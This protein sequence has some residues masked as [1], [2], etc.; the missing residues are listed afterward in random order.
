[1][2]TTYVKIASVSVGSG[3]ASTMDFTSIPSTYT[4]LV[5]KVSSR[6]TGAGSP[7]LNLRFNGSTSTYTQR[8]IMGSGTAASSGTNGTANYLTVGFS[9]GSGHTANSFG[10]SEIYI[11]NYAGSTAKSTS[12]D[13]AEE[14]NE[15]GVY[16]TLYAGLWS[17]T[18]AINQITFYDEVANFAQYTT[19]T[20][21]GISKS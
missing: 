1:M 15:T 16:M 11:P 17:G 5:V 10:S 9:D 4:D 2:A 8:R 6:S 21:Y 3:G 20:L 13:S 19:A 12:T 14:S 7:Y 18:A